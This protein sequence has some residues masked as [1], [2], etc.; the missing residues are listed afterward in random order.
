[1]P[2]GNRHHNR[3]TPNRLPGPAG[4]A[5]H[6]SCHIGC[7]GAGGARRWG[8]NETVAVRALRHRPPA[9]LRRPLTW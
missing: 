1:M 4:R 3:R 9:P 8:V 2:E 6:C 7:R 5:R